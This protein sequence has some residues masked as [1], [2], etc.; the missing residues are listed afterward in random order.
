MD[1][2]TIPDERLE[3]VFTCCHPALD[4]DAQVALTLRTL[5]GLTDRGDRPRLP[6]PRGDDGEAA[7][8][9]EEQDQGRRD[10]VSR[11]AGPSAPR[12]P[13]RGARGRLPDLQR[14]LRR[15]RRPRGRGDP[16]RAR[17]RRADARRARGARTA[18]ADAGERRPARGAVRR[19]HGCPP[20]RPGSIALGLRPDRGGTGRARSRGWR[21][22]AA[23]PTCCRRR[24]Q[25][26]TSR[27]RRTGRSSQPCTASS[28]ASP[29][30]RSWSS[31]RPPRSPKRATLEAA[32]A[33]VESL[34][35][36]QYHYLHATRAELLRRLD[37]VEDARGGLR[38]RARARS[39]GRRA[40][41]PRTAARRAR[42]LTHAA[43]IAGWKSGTRARSSCCGT[44]C[45]CSP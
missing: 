39:L 13:R 16:A 11:A 44:S 7:R 6:R 24:S 33:L 17:A 26:C 15:P 18:G 43:I 4:L 38:P 37:R 28:P 10:P 3:L 32:L 21:S 20:P 36:D 14:G 5:G 9:R 45:S 22:A 35:L 1:E 8:P 27:S 29:A 25:P 40:A 42:R 30:R 12:P 31:T 23:V 19:R 34:D 41:L 2:T